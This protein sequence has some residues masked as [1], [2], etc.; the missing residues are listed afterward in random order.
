MQEAMELL[1]EG[2]LVLGAENR[3][4]FLNHAAARLLEL[5]RERVVGQRLSEAVS[6]KWLL[7]DLA[8]TGRNSAGSTTGP[9][10]EY[11]LKAA[12]HPLPG[13]GNQ[14][15]L[16]LLRDA[17]QERQLEQKNRELT[18]LAKELE[19]IF[20]ASYDEIFVTDGTGTTLWVNSACEAVYGIK[21]EDLVGKNVLAL[22]QQGLFTPSVTTR[23]M[24]EKRRVTLVQTTK[25]GRKLIVTGNPVFA[26][27]GTVR[28]VVINSRDI[29][30]LS[31]LRQKLE[32]VQQLADSYRSEVLEL[33][34]AQVQQDEPVAVSSQFRQVLKL[35]DKLAKVD[36]SVLITGESG[37][38]K[39][40]I[41]KRLHRLSPRSAGPFVPVNCGAIPENLIE[42]EL[43]GYEPGAFTGAKKEGK[44]G[45]FELA[46]GGTI[47]LDEIGELPL[48]LQVKLL[49]VLQEKRV[50]RLGGQ[51]E[52]AVD[53]RLI[54]AT[55]RNLEESVRQGQFRE[56]LYYRLNVVPIPIPSLR[57]R[58]ED[59]LPLVEH[60]LA[61][62][63]QRYETFKCLEPEA[64]RMLTCYQWPG[65]V[66]EVENIVERLVVLTEGPMISPA[67][68]PDFLGGRQAGSGKVVVHDLCTLK[69]G[70]EEV[71]QQLLLK[72]Y[73]KYRNTYRV[74]DVLEI[75]QSTVVRKLN[76]YRNRGV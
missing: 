54:T 68:L 38:G 56:D 70:V 67:N 8:E 1:T 63:C 18:E 52:L 60:F 44:P 29:H 76:K 46:H 57:Q 50:L 35:V 41:A 33:R 66:R 72:A 55:N 75:N 69:Q 27:D 28:R 25:S 64:V 43:F 20:D 5:D 32:E 37:V 23:V 73:E 9:W 62:F 45:L 36:S 10:Q 13:T 65:N 15:T 51:K 19:N 61:K 14:Q 24:E 71:E 74:A 53:V 40:L 3:I 11:W 22:E 17:T 31:S 39:G 12:I 21:A 59:I 7:E 6:C 58:P 47:F 30:E 16:V 4:V 34:Q 26:P 48:S 2:V 49:T 42:S